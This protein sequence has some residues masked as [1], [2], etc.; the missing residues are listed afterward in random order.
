MHAFERGRGE[1][2]AF[3]SFS[4]GRM[5]ETKKMIE[6]ERSCA[7]GLMVTKEEE[8]DKAVKRSRMTAIVKE[9]IIYPIKSC[10][11]IRVDEAITTEYGL[12]LPSNVLLSDRRW[13]I[14][15]N[16]KHQTQTQISKMATI[17][18]EFVPDGLLLKAPN[19]PNLAISVNPPPTEIIEF[20]CYDVSI[21]GRKYGE[22]VS[23]W[24][25]TYL[26]KQNLHLVYFD[27]QFQCRL[28]KD[29][30]PEIPTEARETDLLA[31]QDISPLLLCS[32]E[33]VQ[34]LNKRLE[35]PVK[36]YWRV[37][38][39]GGAKMTWIRP[40][41]RCLMTTINQKTGERDRDYEPWKTLRS[42]R[43]KPEMYG[44][45]P[46]FGIYVAPDEYGLMRLGDE[47]KISVENQNF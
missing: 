28:S 40:C 3:K 30:E 39:I 34:D 46:Q 8:N 6:V 33:S 43:L 44:K 4:C 14:I 29:M 42:Y 37:M 27:N 35:K 32:I 2:T 21:N 38:T 18:P 22:N 5:A 41:L 24:L 9:L 15:K 36:D 7:P 17:Q 45:E 31:Y 11:G 25:S 23:Q 20:K 47:I 13:M 19:M 26:G 1:I 12:A 16:G 10:S